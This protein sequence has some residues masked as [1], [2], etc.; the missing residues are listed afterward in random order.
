[1]HFSIKKGLDLPISG[2]PEQSIFDGNPVKS[3]AVL[4]N[5]YVGMRPTM[6]VE[7]GQKVKL[8]QALF[9]DKKNPG[10][11]FTAPGAGTVRAINRGAKRVL[12]SVVIDLE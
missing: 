10:V 12:Q 6:L 3:V 5:E 7:E 9:E 2:K 1:M 4:G 11:L 8:G